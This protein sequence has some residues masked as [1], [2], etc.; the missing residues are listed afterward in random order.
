MRISRRQFACGLAGVASLGSGAAAAATFDSNT[1]VWW[2]RRVYSPGSALPPLKVLH[3]NRIRP[4]SM[5]RT[6]EGAVYLIA[7]ATLEARVKAWD[8]FN[9]DEEWYPIRDAGNIALQEIR[10]YAG[11]YPGGKIFEISL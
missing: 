9:N 7:F 8:R 11:S 10:V 3:R 4:V 1:A 6:A 2:E 5:A